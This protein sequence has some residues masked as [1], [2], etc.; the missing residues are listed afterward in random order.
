[1]H[2]VAR[3]NMVTTGLPRVVLLADGLVCGLAGVVAVLAAHPAATL[4]GLKW[5]ATLVV[6]GTCL[7][8]CGAWFSWRATRRPVGARLVLAV[9]LLNVAWVAGSALILVSG[10]PALTPEGEWTVG[11]VAVLV[12]LLAEAQFY[13]LWRT[14]RGKHA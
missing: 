10:A 5:P 11:I 8:L 12:A 6:F 14:R 1:M 4:L 7:L 2:V 3:T 9:A 13:A